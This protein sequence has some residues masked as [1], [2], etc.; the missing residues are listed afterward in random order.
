MG[1]DADLLTELLEMLRDR[2]DDEAV[3][4]LDLGLSTTPEL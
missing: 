1:E 2:V 4:R 3:D